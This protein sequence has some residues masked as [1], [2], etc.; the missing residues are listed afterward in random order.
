[1]KAYRGI[2]NVECDASDEGTHRRM[3]KLLKC[4]RLMNCPSGEE[5]W[6]EN[7]GTPSFNPLALA[8]RHAHQL[9][10]MPEYVN[11]QVFLIMTSCYPLLIMLHNFF[12][13]GILTIA[14]NSLEAAT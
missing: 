7:F 8:Q 14:S 5:M 6:E 9:M 1:M 13:E 4:L 11:F 2:L 10:V 3:G 12:I